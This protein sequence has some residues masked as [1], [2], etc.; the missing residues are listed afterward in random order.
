VALLRP[1]HD[2]LLA[3]PADHVERLL[4][5]AAERELQDVRLDAA[6]DHVPQLVGDAKEAIGRA[7]AVQA[8][9]R[10]AMVVML[11]PQPDPLAGRLEAVELGAGEE[12]LPDR[13][14][15]ALDLAQG[16]RVMRSALEVM[17]PVLLELGLEAGGAPPARELP[18]LIG[19]ELLG[20]AVLG[21]GPA[22]HLEH[23]LRCLTAEDI[24]SHD[25][26]RVI[27]NEADEVGVLATQPEREDVGLPELVGRGTFEAAGRRRAAR[28]VDLGLGEQGLRVELAAHRLSTDR[29]Q[30]HAPE[31][32][33]DLLDPEVR[34][35]ALHRDG[36]RLHG[37]RHL[38][39]AG[40][41]GSVL[42]LQAR[43]ALGT[44]RVDPLPQRAQTEVEIL[45]D[46]G[47][48]EAF[49]HTE[50]NGFASELHGMDVRVWCASSLPLRVF[51]LA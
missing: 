11:H 39:L 43:G 8:L 29:Q 17:D 21:D 40:L 33:A 36:L 2:R 18:A 27:V 15:E 42:P 7:E 41:R 12:L 16:H 6:L 19:E 9:M 3:E 25:V 28:R 44:I 10:A 31:E 4:G 45:G 32:V 26:S 20:D 51:L 35:A 37:R 24:E 5:F 48:R 47:D 30:A 46:L 13:L 38:R 1:D 50:L 14:P 49:L 22:I 34:V 23:V